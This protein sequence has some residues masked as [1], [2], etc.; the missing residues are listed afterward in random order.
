MNKFYKIFIH[1]FILCISSS[2][3]VWGDL[4]TGLIAWYPFDGNASDMSG[5][6]NDGTVHG[7]VLGIDRHGQANKAYNF[8]GVDDYID[9]GNSTSLN[10]ANLITVSAWVSCSS[11]KYAPIVE[12]YEPHQGSRYFFMTIGSGISNHSAGWIWTT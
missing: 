3:N 5:S 6:G 8:D 11:L 1:G 12:R 10:P 2:V 7:P 9:L 4:S